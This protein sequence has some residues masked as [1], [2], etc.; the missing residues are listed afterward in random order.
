MKRL[1]FLLLA[2]SA[3]APIVLIAQG[4]GREPQEPTP[5]F[6]AGVR[7]VQIDALVTDQDG[8]AVRGLTAEDFEIAE[9]GRPRPIT[10]FEAVDLPIERRLPDLAD[11]DVASNEEDGRIFLIVMDAVSAQTGLHAKRV[12]RQFLADHF[13]AGDVASVVFLDRGHA[14]AGQDFTSNRRLLINGI[15][16]FNGYSEFEADEKVQVRSASPLAPPDLRLSTPGTPGSNAAME[17]QI[18]GTKNRMSRLRDLTEFL[19]RMPGRRKA[20]LLVTEAIGFDAKE[21]INY[22]GTTM[23][24]AAVEAHAAMAAATRGNVAIYPIHPGGVENSATLEEAM[25]LRSL[26]SATGG[27]S[28]VNSNNFGDTFARIV[29]ENSTYYMLGFNSAQTRDDGRFVPIAVRVKRP[30]LR[31]ASR[32]GYVAPF[33]GGGSLTPNR[34][35]GIAA[36]LASPVPV[37]GITI[38]AAAAPFRGRGNTAA[39]AVMLDTDARALGLLDQNGDL[40]GNIDV[41][42]V[43]TDVRSKVIPQIAHTATIAIT[44]ADRAAVEAKGVSLFTKA[45][46]PP[47][48]YQLRVAIGTAQRGGSVITDVDVPDFGKDALAISGLVLLAGR[49]PDGILLSREDPLQ[50]LAARAPTTR[51]VFA[52]DETVG[53]LAAIYDAADAQP[54]TLDVD[55]VIRS[56]AGDSTPVARVSL[57]SEELKKSGHSVRFEAPLPLAKLPAGR[58]IVAIE[59]RSSAGGAPVSRTVPFQIR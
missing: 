21:F 51:R 37:G 22:R 6:R 52:A 15:D 13:G 12:L 27:F 41:R 28:H 38:R 14:T 20:M 7:A 45:E 23:N 39:I 57:S 24:P 2:I 19:I 16:S 1:G 36:A 49:E 11:T 34:Q 5:T 33:R 30:G 29:R 3:A 44:A 58:Y 4:T 43:A 26:G 48:R 17:S 46:L 47:G 50:L 40:R 31:V 56:D 59:A 32:E 9:R 10:T 25:E 42:L 18:L 55:A 53:V 8:T 35:T 54:H